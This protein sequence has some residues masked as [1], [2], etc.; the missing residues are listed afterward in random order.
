MRGK[1]GDVLLVG[2]V[3]LPELPDHPMSLVKRLRRSR[4]RLSRTNDFFTN[5]AFTA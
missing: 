5:Y 4:G 1:P 2:S 3:L